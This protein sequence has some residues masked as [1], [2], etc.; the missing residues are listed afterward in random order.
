MEWIMNGFLLLKT[1]IG[2]VLFVCAIVFIIVAF[3]VGWKYMIQE[4]RCSEKIKGSV[5][6]YSKR[7]VGGEYSVIRLPIVKYTV[8]NKEYE[9]V[10]PEY[11]SYRIRS[12]VNPFAS[13][14][15]HNWDIQGQ[16]FRYTIHRKAFINIITNPM[17]EIYPIGTELDVFYDPNRPTLAYVLRYCK[18]KHLFWLFMIAGIVTLIIDIMILILI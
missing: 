13:S 17:K 2:S 14:T 5:C 7:N 12:T 1:I 11:S 4:E 8:D 15:K 3:K 6:A 18:R 16:R 9:I 10:G